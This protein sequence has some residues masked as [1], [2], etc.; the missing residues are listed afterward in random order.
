MKH[1]LTA[2]ITVYQRTLSP[3]HGP[4]RGLF[5][6]G[7][8]RYRPTCSEY[9]KESIQRFGSIKGSWMG[10]K[11]IGRCHPSAAGGHD[12]VPGGNR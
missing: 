5:P 9:T 4:L 6:Y 10:M 8:C 3:D 2:L 11:R 12:P 7:A 1:V